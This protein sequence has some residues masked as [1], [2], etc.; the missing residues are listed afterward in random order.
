MVTLVTLNAVAKHLATL[1]HVPTEERMTVLFN[2]KYFVK[3]V[4][5]T[6]VN[7]LLNGTYWLPCLLH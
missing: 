7:R 3:Y 1:P 2:F 6:Q 5:E 4:T